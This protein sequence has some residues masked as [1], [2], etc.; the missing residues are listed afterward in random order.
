[1]PVGDGCGL[2]SQGIMHLPL[3]LGTGFK[4][5]RR[6][7]CPRESGSTFTVRLRT[8]HRMVWQVRITSCVG[9]TRDQG[10]Y[11]CADKNDEKYRTS[12]LI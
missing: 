5:F 11:L 2:A 4:L 3:P 9:R 6:L 7:R 10:L 12:Y 1:M 8:V